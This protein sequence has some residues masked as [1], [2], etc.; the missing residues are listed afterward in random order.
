MKK[1]LSPA[2]SGASGSLA[3]QAPSKNHA[4][5]DLCTNLAEQVEGEK[6]R[7]LNTSTAAS[8]STAQGC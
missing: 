1:N 5:S 3:V 4:P 8:R 7:A 6:W 2:G